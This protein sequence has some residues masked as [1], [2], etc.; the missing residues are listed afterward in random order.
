MKAFM[1]EEFL[2]D[3]EAARR[4]YHGYAEGKPIIDFHCHLPPAAIADNSRFSGLAEAWLGGDHYKWRAMRSNGVREDLV[5]GPASW[6]D[7]FEAWAATVPRLIG[8]P[9]YHWTHLE[10]KRYFGIDTVLNPSSAGE[11]RKTC[12]A[13]LAGPGY[14]VREL[15]SRMNV[16]AVCTTDDPADDLAFHKSYALARGASDCIMVPCFRPDKAMNADNPAAWNEYIGRLEK[17]SGVSIASWGDLAHALETRHTAFHEAGCRLSD[18]ALEVPV[19]EAATGS[20]LNRLI[21][22]LRAGT[23]PTL[24]EADKLRTA[25][26]KLIG[27]LDEER[28]WTMQLHMGAIR[29]LSSRMFARLGPDT[30]YDA[31]CDGIAAKPLSRFLDMLDREG[32]LPATILYTLNPNWN[33][34]LGTVMGAFQDGSIPGKMQFGSAW[35]FNDQLDGM[36]AQMTSLANMGLLSRFVGMLTDSRSFL[37]F[38]RHEYFRRLLCSIIGSWVERGEAPADYDLLG[39]MVED[40]AWRN[41][42]ARFA[43]PGVAMP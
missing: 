14:S 39:N 33:D 31:I 42:A 21:A 34:M 10:L 30:G 16:K 41:A 23:T 35:W 26:L 19:A 8:N 18:H 38:P 40:I 5:T 29:N 6:E 24:H 25:V 4:L 17:T 20:E 15:L 9:L 1:D 37:S 7:R 27:R 22:S 13:A 11:I 28:G 32:Q 2:L 12:D 3:T 36:R 43:I